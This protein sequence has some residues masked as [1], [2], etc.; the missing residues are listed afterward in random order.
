MINK[1]R[2]RK[3]KINAKDKAKKQRKCKREWFVPNEM[4]TK[5]YVPTG[6]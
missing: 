1:N 6:Q 3:C 5:E 2:K 4:K